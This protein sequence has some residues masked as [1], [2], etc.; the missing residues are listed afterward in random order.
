[1]KISE[2]ILE[3][4]HSILATTKIGPWNVQFDSHAFASIAN[5][6]IPPEDYTN[7]ASYMCFLPDVFPTVPV[8]RGAYFQ[9]TNTRISIYATRVTKDTIRIETVLGPDMQP[10]P[11]LFRRPVP[12]STVKHKNPLDLS[13]LRARTQVL[14]RDAVSQELEKIKPLM[15]VNRAERRK[16]SK[17]AKKINRIK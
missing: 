11:P 13:Q 3:A 4:H 2:I 5:R 14:G 17:F 9:D 12:P 1:M 7:I 16:F 6:G 8:G 15:P 10:K